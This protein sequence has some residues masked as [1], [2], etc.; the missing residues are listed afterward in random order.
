MGAPFGRGLA[1][2]GGAFGAAPSLCT[3]PEPQMSYSLELEPARGL[4]ESF[5]L[6]CLARVSVVC[7]IFLRRFSGILCP[8]YV[9]FSFLLLSEAL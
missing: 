4:V 8:Q 5:S 9:V 1:A 3:E 6:K 2:F 7:R